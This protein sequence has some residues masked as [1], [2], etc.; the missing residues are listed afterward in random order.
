[1]SDLVTP[2]GPVRCYDDELVRMALRMED[3]DEVGGDAVAALAQLYAAEQ[4]ANRE[5][6]ARL[7]AIIESDVKL[8]ALVVRAELSGDHRGGDRTAVPVEGSGMT[9]FVWRCDEPGC[10]V[11]RPGTYS[12]PLSGPYCPR[13]PGI[14]LRRT[15]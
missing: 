1:M 5:F 13:H 15:P 10:P 12:E 2:D 4:L 11:K 8:G 6:A 3:W 9:A 7:S 14:R